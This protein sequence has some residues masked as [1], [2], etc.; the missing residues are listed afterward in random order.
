MKQFYPTPGQRTQ[1]RIRK[2]LA[3]SR[4]SCL[5]HTPYACE[6]QV[7]AAVQA[8]D[9][10]R[11][12][13]TYRQMSVS[14]RSGFLPGDLLHQNQILFI[15]FV[16]LITRAAMEGGMPEDLAYAMS[17]AYL[18]LMED[19]TNTGTLQALQEQALEDFTRAVAEFRHALPA[20]RPVRKAVRFFRYHLQEPLTLE[21]AAAEAGV[22][23]SRLSHLFQEEMGESPM[24]YLRRQRL[25]SACILLTESALP[26]SQI[27]EI[28]CFGSASRFGQ[29]FRRYTGMTPSQYRQGQGLP[30][31]SST[32][33]D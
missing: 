5:P 1:S 28:L 14:G 33:V 7:L 21:Q 30:I 13:E 2:I 17:D 22:S 20:S 31:D 10:S 3:E 25:E 18:Q 12:Q 16:T 8:G 27:S 6:K 11:A 19:C 24:A 23:P 26:I 32:S 29:A 4:A 9:I 15:S